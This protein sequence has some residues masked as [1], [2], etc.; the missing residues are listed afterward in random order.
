[1]STLTIEQ[2]RLAR[3]ED[4]VRRIAVWAWGNDRAPSFLPITQPEVFAPDD[5]M[6][7]DRLRAARKAARLSAKDLGVRVGL[8]DV[9]VRAHETGQNGVSLE[10][11][12]T[13]ADACGC[14]PQWLAWGIA[15]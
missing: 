15:Q 5:S 6:L 1:M 8:T 11:A 10:L 2:V 14:T 9:S 4:E 3:L 13:Y 7:G 12:K